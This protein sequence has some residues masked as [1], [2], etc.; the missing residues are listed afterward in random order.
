MRIGEYTCR[1]A[2]RQVASALRAALNWVRRATI[3]DVRDLFEKL[4]LNEAKR[5]EVRSALLDAFGPQAGNS[6]DQAA[7]APDIADWSVPQCYTQLSNVISG[8]A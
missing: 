6:N 1:S 4:P 7:F 3:K 5:R 2:N 8:P